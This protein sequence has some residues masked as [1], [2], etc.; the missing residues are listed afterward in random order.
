MAKCTA[1]IR[2]FT[3]GTEVH[4]EDENG[5]HSRHGGTLRDYAYPG[6]ETVIDWYEE[7]RR[8]FRGDWSP[9]PIAVVGVAPACILPSGHHGEHAY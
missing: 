1:K 7:D 4:C 5:A 9:C 6:S 8:T 3:D 2:P